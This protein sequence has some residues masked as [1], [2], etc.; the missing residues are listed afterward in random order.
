ME[1]TKYLFLKFDNA[2]FFRDMSKSKDFTFDLNGKAK[3]AESL[4]YVEPIT[5]HQISNALHVLMGERPVPS[6][7]K[8][9]MTR[10]EDIFDIATNSYLK[11]DTIKIPNKTNG[12]WRFPEQTLT[13]RKAVWN[14]F[15]TAPTLITWERVRRILENDLFYQYISLLNDLF[16]ID[17]RSKYTC[18]EA[19]KL[20][21]KQFSND[22]R[23][24][25]FINL[26]ND[27]GKTPVVDFI[28][29]GQ[30]LSKAGM[31]KGLTPVPA[32]FNANVRTLRTT[33]FGVDNITRLR[34]EIIVP[35]SDEYLE[36]IR[37]NKGVATIL[38]GG[39]LW[40]DKVVDSDD[41]SVSMIDGFTPV[42]EISSE[43]KPTKSKKQTDETNS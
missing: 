28:N 17:V 3:R 39:L 32:T 26:L 33:N 9:L 40:I 21:K 30:K 14:S 37:N 25:N 23:L 18:V 6:L 2:G 22:V 20:L 7:R 19:N 11:I 29:G 24:K 36:K 1:A 10:I 34:G 13:M 38:D 4:Q 41:M 15:S 31:E 35:M 16:Q 5:V 8:S 43:T 12:T 27:E 42:S